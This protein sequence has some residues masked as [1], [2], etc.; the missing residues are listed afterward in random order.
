MSFIR[1]ILTLFDS[2]AEVRTMSKEMVDIP[3]EMRERIESIIKEQVG[4]GYKSLEDFILTACQKQL[5]RLHWDN[6][7]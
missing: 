7:S 1:V 5:M 3:K 4:S 2:H 6:D